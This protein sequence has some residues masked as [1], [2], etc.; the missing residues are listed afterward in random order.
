MDMDDL[1]LFGSEV[2][3]NLAA[4][5]LAKEAAAKKAEESVLDEFLQLQER[6]NTNAALKEQFKKIQTRMIN[7]PDYRKANNEAFV[8]GI[9]LLKLGDE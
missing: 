7:D 6:I 2:F 9:M 3:R 1:A 5:E 4:Q 8:Q